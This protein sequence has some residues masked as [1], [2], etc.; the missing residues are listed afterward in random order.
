MLD[1]QPALKRALLNQYQAILVGGAVA[2]SAILANPLPLLFLVGSELVTMPFVV[3]KLR[4]RIELEKKLVHRNVKTIS[5]EEQF[6]ELTAEARARFVRVRGLCTQIQQ[7]YRSL[8]PAS[9]AMLAEQTEKF[10]AILISC[11]RRLWLLKKHGD[12]AGN[13]DAES[14]Q[15]DVTALE[16]RLR[17]GKISGRNREACVQNLEI[18]R[19]LLETVDRNAAAQTTLAT[20]LDSVEALLQLL[21]Q[22]S[23]AASDADVLAADL[24]DALSQAEA[25][26]ASVRE[27]E[28]AVGALP[29]ASRGEPLSDRLKTVTAAQVAPHPLPPRVPV[30]EG[31]GGRRPRT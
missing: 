1:R 21:L 13:F 18:K 6:S 26:A 12:L 8:S 15:R 27:M 2:V 20:E 5:Q 28:E 14:V 24:D 31:P 3:D 23:L 10:D 16:E 7:N 4:R 19:R 17:D 29:T 30:G 22:K 9:Q 11:L 25:D